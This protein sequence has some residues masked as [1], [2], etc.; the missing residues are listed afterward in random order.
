MDR[1]VE[2]LYIFRIDDD[3]TNY[4]E[5]LWSIPEGVTYNWYLLLS[6][7]KTVLF[8]GWKREYAGKLVEILREVADPRD[9]DYVVVH[10]MEQDH[11]GSLPKI[12]E[13]NGGR[14]E[15]LGH[16]LTGRMIRAFYGLNPRFRGVKDGESFLVGGKTLRFLYT[17]WLHWPETIMTYIVEDAVLLS[18]D[19]FG[20][21][22]IPPALFDSDEQVVSDYFKHVRKYV[23][24]IVGRYSDYKL[25]L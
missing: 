5:A 2:D 4:F 11:S 18:C 25:R 23:V 21:F 12:L 7:D 22:S 6:G 17:P 24:D 9:V 3:E 14:A 1:V 15:V 20:S 16:P 19:A 10:H 13:V 8:D